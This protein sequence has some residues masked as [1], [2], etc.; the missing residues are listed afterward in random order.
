MIFEWTIPWI[1]P[2]WCIFLKRDD[3]Y[4]IIHL[5]QKRLNITR[6]YGPQGFLVYSC[7]HFPTIFRHFYIKGSK[8]EGKITNWSG[9]FA[10]ELVHSFTQASNSHLYSCF[11]AFSKL[12]I[13]LLYGIH[14]TALTTQQKSTVMNSDMSHILLF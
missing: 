11:T 12:N 7:L 10:W 9:L 5:N 2:N 14:L 6:Q 13:T 3:G 1:I 4:V 8:I